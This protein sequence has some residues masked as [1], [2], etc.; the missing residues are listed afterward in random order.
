MKSL[1]SFAVPQARQ[2]S[3]KALELQRS[4][5]ERYPR[6]FDDHDLRLAMSQGKEGYHFAEWLGAIIVSTITGYDALVSKYQYPKH[7]HKRQVVAA[8]GLTHVLRLK[9]PLFGGTQGPDLLMYRP[10]W[11]DFFF[12][13]VKRPG[14]TLK[15]TQDRYFRYLESETRKPVRLLQLKWTT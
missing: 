5:A 4:W 14:D 12:C 11:S 6:L 1:G 3:W 2:D 10:D 15:P 8:L 13:E 9:H 7:T